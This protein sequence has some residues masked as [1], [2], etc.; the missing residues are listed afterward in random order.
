MGD[1]LCV[2]VLA[3]CACVCAHACLH[4]CVRAS[5]AF[6]QPGGCCALNKSNTDIQ[7]GLPYI[8]HVLPLPPGT[9]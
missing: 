5:N 8:M 7:W 4:V 3:L 2:R 9:R 6:P 1:L